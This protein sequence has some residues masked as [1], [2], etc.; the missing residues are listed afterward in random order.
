MEF[1]SKYNI[2]FEIVIN[3]LNERIPRIYLLLK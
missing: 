2:D 1:S 3:K